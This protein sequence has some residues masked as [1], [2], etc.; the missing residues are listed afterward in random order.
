MHQGVF[1]LIWYIVFGFTLLGVLLT[2]LR[3]LL[4]PTVSDRVV[5]VDSMTTITTALMVFL[6]FLF[7]RYVYLDI[8]LVYAVLAFIATLTI[9][10]YMEGGL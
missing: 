3:A 7:D 1:E 4:G 2:T 9:A 6:A 8:A 10:R 5:A